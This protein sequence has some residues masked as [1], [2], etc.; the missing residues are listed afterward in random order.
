MDAK[1]GRDAGGQPVGRV[2]VGPELLLRH[3]A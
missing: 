2:A 3:A 1:L